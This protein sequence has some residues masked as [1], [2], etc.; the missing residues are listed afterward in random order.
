MKNKITATLL[1]FATTLTFNGLMAQT[2]GPVHGN[3]TEPEVQK[4]DDRSEDGTYN[5]QETKERENWKKDK[6]RKGGK[7]NA[8]NNGKKDKTSC[9]EGTND[10]TGYQG[11]KRAE[12]HAKGLNKEEFKHTM[13]AGKGQMKKEDKSFKKH[14]I[15]ER[16]AD[17]RNGKGEKG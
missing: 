17:A 12:N 9:E 2:P 4:E 7:E 6:G 11:Q 15:F 14:P 5:H 1:F 16:R 8:R 10:R 13:R 3:K